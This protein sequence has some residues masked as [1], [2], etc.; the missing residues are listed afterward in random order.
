MTQ[1]PGWQPSLSGPLDETVMVSL[2]LETTGLDG[3]SD[4][5][6]EIGAVKFRGGEEIEQ[7]SA[8]VN[9]G[10]DIP[11]FITDLTGISNADVA[12][13]PPIE[14]ILPGLIEFLGNHPMIG[15]NVAFDAG[16]LVR[17]GVPPRTQTFDT[18]DLAYALIPGATE[19]NLGGLGIAMGL[20]HDAPHR[21]LSDALVTR[22]LF[23]LML[24]KLAELPPGVL[25]E[26]SRLAAASG[27]STGVLAG[28]ILDHVDSAATFQ[29]AGF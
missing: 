23:L 4:K 18:Y 10:R 16:F 8:L 17:N 26:F 3:R 27:W 14:K 28:R 7:Y 6:I 13:A 25:S 20:V 5:I 22:D 21:A 9:P 12:D 19:Y 15:H 29:A 1:F 11:P 2:D 24:D